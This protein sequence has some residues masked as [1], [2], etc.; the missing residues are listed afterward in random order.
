MATIDFENVQGR[1]SAGVGHEPNRGFDLG[2]QLWRRHLSPGL[3]T[4]AQSSRIWRQATQVG[5]TPVVD[6]ISARYGTDSS[7]FRTWDS[8]PFVMAKRKLHIVSRAIPDVDSMPGPSMTSQFDG[9]AADHDHAEPAQEVPTAQSTLRTGLDPSTSTVPP[10]IYRRVKPVGSDDG[11]S[12]QR[13]TLRLQ[14]QR[15]AHFDEGPTS[16]GQLLTA[17]EPFGTGQCGSPHPIVVHPPGHVSDSASILRRQQND[18][19]SAAL[20]LQGL[21]PVRDAFVSKRPA[22]VADQSSE[23]LE[24]SVVKQSHAKFGVMSPVTATSR[25]QQRSGMKETLQPM[26]SVLRRVTASSASGL[27]GTQLALQPPIMRRVLFKTAAPA[28]EE[29]S[30]RIPPGNFAGA[31]G[32]TDGVSDTRGPSEDSPRLIRTLASND[33]PSRSP[34]SPLDL[35]LPHVEAMRPPMPLQVASANAPIVRSP[36]PMGA[37]ATPTVL[38]KVQRIIAPRLGSDIQ[39]DSLSGNRR[40]DAEDSRSTSLAGDAASFH[41]GAGHSSMNGDSFSGSARSSVTSLPSLVHV[42]GPVRPHTGPPTIV[43][44]SPLSGVTHRADPFE[45]RAADSYVPGSVAHGSR[46]FLARQVVGPG[47][48]SETRSGAAFMNESPAQVGTAQSVSSLNIAEMAEQ[49]SR[50]MTRR[51]TA[52]R[53]RR[54]R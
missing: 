17:H 2:S 20:P 51:L 42:A 26:P 32:S 45:N 35:A 6:H 13:G 29:S 30:T 36:L 5:R 31:H 27:E 18:L 38:R 15:E 1:S 40:G 34:E 12:S 16:P 37:L 24:S 3:I 19:N 48:V 23:Q 33:G 53:E 9:L 39:V 28:S 21:V 44:R 41:N 10:T 54:G 8:L 25:D 14:G 11:I 52:E 7:T 22:D 50:L 47:V 4:H 43:W 46:S 49:V